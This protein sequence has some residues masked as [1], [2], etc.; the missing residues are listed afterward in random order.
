MES[1]LD[2][3]EVL[4][5]LTEFAEREQA[6]GSPYTAGWFNYEWYGIIASLRADLPEEV[7]REFD[8]ARQRK[9]HRPE[10]GCLICTDS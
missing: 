5:D 8:D 9:K 10:C 4:T 7:V 1:K 6:K 3:L 2:R